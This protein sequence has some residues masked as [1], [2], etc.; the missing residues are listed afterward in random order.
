PGGDARRDAG[1]GRASRGEAL[2]P[3]GGRAGCA[4]PAADGLRP[5]GPAEPAGPVPDVRFRQPG[6]VGRAPAADDGP[7]TGPVR[8]ERPIRPRAGEGPG[9]PVRRPGP[10]R[11]C[12]E[13]L[14]HPPAPRPGP[15]RDASRA[16]VRRG[17]GRG[18][19][20][21]PAGGLGP[22]RPGVI[23]DERVHVRGLRGLMQSLSRREWLL[24]TGT[25]LGMLG[26]AG[27]LADSRLLSAGPVVNPLAPKKPHF[28]A[29]ARH[30]IQV[31]LNGGPSKIDTFAPKRELKKYDGKKLP[32]GNLTTER[33]TGAALPS[34]FKFQKYGHSGIE[35]SEL[36]AKTAAHVDDICFIRSM[37]PNTPNHEHSSRLMNCG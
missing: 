2:R 26:L 20:E 18:E 29:R 15:E 35:I 28:P 31:Y 13:A 23:V 24:R 7:A 34:P 21:V 27:V 5:R 33:P 1:R 32:A 30:I 11:A 9:R 8:D 25:G 37:H 12:V 3:A 22:V 16:G 17:S 19:R 4:E 6:P 10:R 14:P 36:F